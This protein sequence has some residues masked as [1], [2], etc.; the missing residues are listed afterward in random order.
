MYLET[1]EQDRMYQL[2]DSSVKYFHLKKSEVR[3][4]LTKQNV[5]WISIFGSRMVAYLFFFN[6]RMVAYLFKQKIDKK[7]PRFFKSYSMFI[8][9]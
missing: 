9:Y 5:I 1:E 8:D 4:I 7:L 3:S 6:K 2:S